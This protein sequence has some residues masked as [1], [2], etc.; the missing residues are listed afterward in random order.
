MSW[1]EHHE[2]EQHQQHEQQQG[3][4]RA[5]LD[6]VAGICPCNKSTEDDQRRSLFSLASICLIRRTQVVCTSCEASL[7]EVIRL[8]LARVHAVMV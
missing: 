2:L 4:H 1:M 7:Q 8:L 5:I 6:G 3:I